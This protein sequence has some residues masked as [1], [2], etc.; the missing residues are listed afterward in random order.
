MTTFVPEFTCPKCGES[1]R[2]TVL[3]TCTAALWE[4]ETQGVDNIDWDDDSEAI[5]DNGA[6]GRRCD[7]EGTVA[8]LRDAACTCEDLTSTDAWCAACDMRDAA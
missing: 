5:C 2:F 3:A 1:D 7:W 8:D 6:P 4:G